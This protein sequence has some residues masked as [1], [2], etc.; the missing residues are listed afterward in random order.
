[1]GNAPDCQAI[2]LLASCLKQVAYLCCSLYLSSIVH[3]ACAGTASGLSDMPASGGVSQ[4]SLRGARSEADDGAPAASSSSEGRHDDNDECVALVEQ[5]D[6]E[7]LLDEPPSPRV[8]PTKEPMRAVRTGLPQVRLSHV[9]MYQESLN[10]ASCNMAAC[11]LFDS[12]DLAVKRL[13]P[14]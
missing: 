2:D 3:V 7:D 9:S 6:L 1:M 12:V 14:G 4:G 13:P 8:A 10:T 5:S 11:C